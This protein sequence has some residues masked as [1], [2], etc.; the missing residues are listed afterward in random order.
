MFP[1][2]PLELKF[3]LFIGS[4]IALSI[5]AL[6]FHMER[7]S[8]DAIM[9]QVDRQARVLLQQVIVTRS[10]VADHGGVY[11]KAGPEVRANPFLAGR[12]IV[13]REG[14]K[15]VMRNPALTTRELSEYTARAGLYSFR[16]SSLLPLNPLNRATPFEE[17][18]LR[19]FNDKGFEA[20]REGLATVDREGGKRVYRR[21]IPLQVE[22]GCLGCH[23]RQGYRVGDIRGGLSVTL[24]LTEADGL[25]ARSRTTLVISAFAII[26]LVLGSIYLLIQRIILLPI[27]HLHQVADDLTAGRYSSRAHLATGDE[28]EK[29]AHAFNSMTDEIIGGY[30]AAVKTLAA[31]VEARDPYTG[32]HIDRVA[33]YAMVIAA[34]FGLAAERMPEVELGAVLHDIG[35]IG[36]P[37][38][39]LRKPGH[40]DADE[41][42]QMKTHPRKGVE[43]IASSKFLAPVTGVILY[44]HERYDGKGYPCGLRGEEIPIGARILAVADTYDAM[45]TDRPYRPGLSRAA[46]ADEIGRESGAQFDPQVVA[47]FFRASE[48]GLLD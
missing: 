25:I 30:E 37:D 42:E 47:A 20:S 40:L 35:K 2:I 5:G 31:A 9:D 39:V 41:V 19:Q 26:L 15:Y 21:I 12:D 10:W 16:L 4:I 11:V 44:H 46:A 27:T 17:R 8:T 43:I 36:I 3:I 1:R 29:L 45:T 28:L 7:Q 34:E 13:D 48:R 14:T 22:S 33:R 18:S 38:S 24:P 23:A 32:G 6:F